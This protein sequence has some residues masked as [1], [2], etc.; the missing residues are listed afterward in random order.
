MVTIDEFTYHC[1]HSILN[2]GDATISGEI[3]KY[4]LKIITD[5]AIT[6]RPGGV[7]IKQQDIEWRQ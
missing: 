6:A 4:K 2:I 7:R 3:P 5:A 1:W